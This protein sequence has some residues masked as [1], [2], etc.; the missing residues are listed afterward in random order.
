M[1]NEIPAGGMTRLIIAN[2]QWLVKQCAKLMAM[3]L[4]TFE[5]VQ[6][7]PFG[8]HCVVL[9]VLVESLG[10][11][12]ETVMDL[13]DK[14]TLSALIVL[15]HK[16]TDHLERINLYCCF[17]RAQLISYCCSLCNMLKETAVC[18]K[19]LVYYFCDSGH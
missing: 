2:L 12:K 17:R 4:E 10:S 19:Y 8:N 14:G 13:L 11:G 5:S 6:P 1:I 3:S 16:Y 15:K 9:L 7:N 18:S